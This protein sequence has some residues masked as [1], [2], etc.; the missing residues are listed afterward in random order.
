MKDIRL[1]RKFVEVATSEGNKMLHYKGSYWNYYYMP[2]VKLE[3]NKTY[4]FSYWHRTLNGSVSK[5]GIVVLNNS[6]EFYENARDFI[7][8]PRD[9]TVRRGEWTLCSV[10]FK[11]YVDTEVSFCIY[12]HDGEA[13]FDKFRLFESE[14]GYE[15]SLEEDMPKGGLTFSD[16]VLGT[17]GLVELDEE[18]DEFYLGED[19]ED[20]FFTEEE[21]D[22]EETEENTTKVI[23][24]YKKKPSAIRIATWFIILVIVVAVVVL[25]G[26]TFLIIFLV[27]RKKKKK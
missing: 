21:E 2:K 14:N 23:R 24:K 13:V 12:N 25:A 8:A 11:T 9:M 7:A 27:K 4:T 15:L 18:D 10:T 17:D 6:P 1:K 20:Y 16:T 22:G 5:F 3:A 26:V 19:D